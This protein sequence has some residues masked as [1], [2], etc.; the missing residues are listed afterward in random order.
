ML[1]QL[2]AC[3]VSL[4]NQGRMQRTA[5]SAVQHEASF[6]MFDFAILT[7]DIKGPSKMPISENIFARMYC[8]TLSKRIVTREQQ[9][10]QMWTLSQYRVLHVDSCIQ[11]T[12]HAATATKSTPTPRNRS[13]F[14]YGKSRCSVCKQDLT[15]LA[16]LSSIHTRHRHTHITCNS[17]LTSAASQDCRKCITEAPG[18][19]QASSDCASAL[20]L[21]S[22]LTTSG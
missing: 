5:D 14:E 11:N 10:Q 21:H 19:S 8:L 6:V 20:R 17:L 18:K 4:R 22:T 9:M 15:P 7:E 2:S 13:N 16:Q 1:Q 3:V 12:L